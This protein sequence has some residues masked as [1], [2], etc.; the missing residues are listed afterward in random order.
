MRCCGKRVKTGIDLPTSDAIASGP[1]TVSIRLSP[2][3]QPVMQRRVP[4]ATA[5]GGRAK[6]VIR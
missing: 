2:L 4:R 3:R 6:V 5:N 1:S